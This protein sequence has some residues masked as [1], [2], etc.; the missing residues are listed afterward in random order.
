MIQHPTLTLDVGS[1][2]SYVTEYRALVGGLKYLA[3]THLDI[4][5]AINKL[6]QFIHRPSYLHWVALRRFL[7][8]FKWNASSWSHGLS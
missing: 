7:S 4:A 2:I 5:F 8:L 3:L 1:P 6:S